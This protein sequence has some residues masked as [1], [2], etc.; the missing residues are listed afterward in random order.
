MKKESISAIE[1]V[2]VK[3]TNGKR[4]YKKLPEVDRTKNI[5]IQNLQTIMKDREMSQE[6]LSEITGISKSSISEWIK[7]DQ[8]PR[9]DTVII[10]ADKLNVSTDYLLGRTNIKSPDQL[11]Q[12]I[13][14]ET[15]LTEK[16]VDFLS[17]IN[18]HQVGDC[19][20]LYTNK[21][22]IICQSLC[23][24]DRA[25]YIINFMLE[26]NALIGML[27]L[28]FTIYDDKEKGSIYT[29]ERANSILIEVITY[30]KEMR[31]VYQKHYEVA[32]DGK[33]AL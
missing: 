20:T 23:D 24:I 6:T 33:D 16:S 28:F 5:F 31:D 17:R 32:R 4:K 11:I 8:M 9:C 1:V 29:G 12:S 26:N 18:K 19:F 3:E 10:L 13:C 22:S 21:D 27:Y 2:E 30:M 14:N 25:I 15:G 7:K